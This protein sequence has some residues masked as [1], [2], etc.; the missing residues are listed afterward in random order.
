MIHLLLFLL[1]SGEKAGKI[2]PMKTVMISVVEV[3]AGVKRGRVARQVEAQVESALER[4][5]GT[6]LV[7]EL[8]VRNEK[9]AKRYHLSQG[10][11]MT[12]IGKNLTRS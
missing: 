10:H 1:R 11:E 3:E 9:V 7:T 8:M 4:K 12:P 2:V 5:K 6:E